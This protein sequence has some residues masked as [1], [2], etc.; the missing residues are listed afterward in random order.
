MAASSCIG[1]FDTEADAIK[2]RQTLLNAG[3]DASRIALFS[4][5]GHAGLSPTPAERLERLGVQE[6]AVHCY[7]C[8]LHNGASLVVVQGS[9]EEIERAFDVLDSHPEADV[10]LHFN[11]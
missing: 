5:P 2:A 6:G 3:I 1:V 9:Y 10:A 7:L 8:L 4:S 11:A